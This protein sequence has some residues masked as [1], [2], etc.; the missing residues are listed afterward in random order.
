MVKRILYIN[1]SERRFV[2]DPSVKKVE[3]ELIE[4]NIKIGEAE[5]QRQQDFLRHVLHDDLIF[6]R[7][8]G[9]IV[10]KQRYLAELSDQNNTYEYL[11]S[12]EVK[13]T[14]YEG[15]AVVS[16]RVRAKGKRGNDSFEGVYRNIRLF[17]KDHGWFCVV[18]FNTII[19][20]N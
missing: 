18:W 9:K 10:N 11:I 13:P 8:S 16:L 2:T 3:N 15:I 17:L 5:K 12:E 6:R 19:D 14:V 4:L 1:V 7:A 20:S